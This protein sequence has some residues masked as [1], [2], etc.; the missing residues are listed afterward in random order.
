LILEDDPAVARV[1]SDGLRE[2][3]YRFFVLRKKASAE[4][5]L[6]RVRPD[7]IIVDYALVGGSGMQAAQMA[8]AAKV[9]VVVMSGHIDVR[10]QVEAF[11]FIFLQ[12]PFRIAELLIV[13][14]KLADR[15]QPPG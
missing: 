1:L 12:K 3:G 15:D 6:R 10:E 11:G 13:A 4:R 5:F 9:P 8:A 14:G 7:L 2:A